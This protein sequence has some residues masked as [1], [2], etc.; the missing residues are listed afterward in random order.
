MQSHSDF[1][2]PWC[3]SL[4]SSNISI[5]DVPTA[6]PRPP[7]SDTFNSMFAR[8]LYSSN[9]I[10]SQINFKRRTREY[11][12]IT[13]PQS[14]EPCEWCYLL[15][16]GDGVDG[17]PG[18]AHG[19]F[20]ALIMDQVTGMVASEASGTRAPATATMTVDYK[21]PID[22]PSVVLCRAWV[23][24]M[25]GRKTWIRG[26]IENGEGKVLASAKALFVSARPGSI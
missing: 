5:T 13:T 14:A 6:R 19:G 21:A 25:A 2:L 4:L 23:I 7:E 17:K 12:A 26:V 24:E 3:Q 11:D 9:A 16:V 22:T 10:R 15:S 18:R 1:D 20:N 8:T